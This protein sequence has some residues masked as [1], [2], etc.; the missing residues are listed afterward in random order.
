M[1]DTA[2]VWCVKVRRFFQSEGHQFNAQRLTRFSQQSRQLNQAGYA[3]GIV[4][5]AGKT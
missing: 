2:H 4:V 1:N 5:G 3:A